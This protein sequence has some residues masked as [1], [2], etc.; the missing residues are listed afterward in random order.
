MANE[1]SS[2]TAPVLALLAFASAGGLTHLY[3]SGKWPF[4][5][6]RAN[7]AAKRFRLEDEPGGLEFTL[8]DLKANNPYLDPDE[9]RAIQSLRVGDSVQLGGG[10]WA[11]ATLT[12]VA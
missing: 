10:A 7:P 11:T 2:W 1:S 12:R 9:L 8:D 4:E 5:S 6:R 3:T